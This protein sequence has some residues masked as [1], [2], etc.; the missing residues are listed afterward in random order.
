ME[1]SS[2]SPK[3][4]GPRW[5]AASFDE[6]PD[7]AEGASGP[8]NQGLRHGLLH[9][10]GAMREEGY[11]PAHDTE[12]GRLLFAIYVLSDM[13]QEGKTEL[14]WLIA[15]AR[16]KD[17]SWESIAVGLG[18]KTRQGAQRRFGALVKE[19]LIDVELGTAR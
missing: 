10:L 4:D 8:P 2:R 12:E 15:E 6:G 5:S 18:L 14:S 7:W 13:L 9:A 17:V 11:V 16:H 19:R 1:H 3:D